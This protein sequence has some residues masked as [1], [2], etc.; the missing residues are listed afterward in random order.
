[1]AEDNGIVTAP[2]SIRDVNKAIGARHTD[3]AALLTDTSVNMWAKY[4]GERIAS[5]API[6]FADRCN[7]LFGLTHGTYTTWAALKAAYDGDLNGWG[8][9]RPIGGAASPY[10]LTDFNG[11]DHSAYPLVNGFTVD[12][13]VVQGGRWTASCF[14]NPEGEGSK[15]VSLK[16]FSTQMYFGVALLDSGG[17]VVYHGTSSNAND[18]FVT[19]TLTGINQATYTAWPFLCT[20]AIT[21]TIGS[22]AK[23]YTFWTLPKVSPTTMRV[24]SSSDPSYYGIEADGAWTNAEHT[25]IE[26]T[27][28]STK[29]NYTGGIYIRTLGRNWTQPAQ[30]S[31]GEKDSGAITITSA[32][33]TRVFSDM[34][35]TYNYHAQVVIQTTGTQTA[36]IEV[37][38]RDDY[39]G[40]QI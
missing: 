22:F 16:D 18:T 31:L 8:Y 39:F 24:T 26:I 7:N 28:S 20:E 19:F 6:S 23:N 40:S 32:P 11:Y 25:R 17:N 29:S 30:N 9:N 13:L 2:V 27:V 35:S 3:V 12:K 5:I 10:R 21:P 15:S 37:P 1:M 36:V 34:L 14:S 38:I 4:K 33:F